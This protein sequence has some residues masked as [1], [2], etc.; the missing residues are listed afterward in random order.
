MRLLFLLLLLAG[1][2]ARP[3]PMLVMAAQPGVL[4]PDAI[5]DQPG[6]PF[7]TA[8]LELLGDEKLALADFGERLR[9]RTA[10]VSGGLLTPEV[11]R[12]TGDG[13]IRLAAREPREKRIALVLIHANYTDRWPRLAG[14]A[15]DA[16][17]VTAGLR[18]AGFETEL[19]LDPARDAR[20]AALARFAAASEQADVAVI[21]T[22]GHGVMHDD[23]SFLLD[24]DFV[25]GWREEKLADHALRIAALAEALRSRRAN[26][27]LFGG[28]RTYEWW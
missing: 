28:C 17:R 14:A 19:L 15:H 26:L 6:N 16:A 27:L 7:A 8:F 18:K 4:A 5:G 1:C 3:A 24:S 25:R 13:T 12:V 10:V 22:T 23:Q 2:A 20:T 21:Y 9:E 11:A